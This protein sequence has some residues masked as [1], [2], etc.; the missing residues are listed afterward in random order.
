VNADQLAR[1]LGS[2]WTLE[3]TAATEP[4]NLGT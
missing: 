2:E 3:R 1:L 4:G